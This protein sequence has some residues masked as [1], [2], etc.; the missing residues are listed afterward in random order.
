MTAREVDRL[1][2]IGLALGWI[3]LAATVR[4]SWRFV[5]GTHS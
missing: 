2:I 5:L 3:S 4:W 1:V